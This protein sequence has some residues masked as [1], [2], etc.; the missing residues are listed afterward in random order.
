[1]AVE[2]EEAMRLP[3]AFGGF[4][5]DPAYQGQLLLEVVKVR[6]TQNAVFL[7]EPFLRFFLG[8]GHISPARMTISPTIGS[9]MYRISSGNA[10]Q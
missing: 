6:Y 5:I 10:I 9:S 1:M 3:Q 8:G 2:P 7:I 4:A